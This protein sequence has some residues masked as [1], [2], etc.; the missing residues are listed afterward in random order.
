M[1]ASWRERL[2][3]IKWQLPIAIGL[4]LLIV[5]AAV[6]TNAYREVHD[7]ALASA[8]TRLQDVGQQLSTLLEQSVDARIAETRAVAG[9][10]AVAGALASRSPNAR[11]GAR[12]A[13]SE[14]RATSPQITAVELWDTAGERVA[15]VQDPVAV[16][17][18]SRE[19][20]RW[21]TAGDTIAV[22]GFR[23]D[24]EQI[25]YAVAAA[26]RSQGRIIGHV[27]Q[28][29]LLSS[30]PESA[31]LIE[32]LIGMDAAFFF[33]EPG[34]P[35]TDLVGLVERPNLPVASDGRV[36]DY[37]AADGVERLG[38]GTPVAATPWLVWVE[39]PSAVILERPHSF[40]A[41]TVPIGLAIV[42][43]GATGGWAVS[44]RFT[45][46][47]ERVTASAMALAD[48]RDAD[49]LPTDRRD[50]LGRLA[51]AFNV[52]AKRVR[53]AHRD[54]ETRVEERTAELQASRRVLRRHAR[55]LE[56]TN[57][58]LEAFSY[59]VSHDLRAP[60]RSI[61]GFS[62]ALLED[63]ADQLDER[64]TDYLNRVSAA[65]ERMGELI[66]DLLDLSRL[67]RGEL[68]VES[69]D[70]S[71]M[72]RELASELR[73]REPERE[74]EFR[75]ADDVRVEGDPHLLRAVVENLIENAWKFTADEAET[76]IEFGVADDDGERTF[77][78]RDNGAGFDMEYVD[79]L[80]GAFQ[81]LHSR[82][83][84]P[85]SGIGLAT[86]KRIVHR[87]GGRVRAEGEVGRGATFYFTLDAATDHGGAT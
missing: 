6:G 36:R 17:A 26:V 83:D 5:V 8:G 87:H 67:T 68:S 75:I 42:L 74:A 2:R 73:R 72:V 49:P 77:F 27:V 65:A 66:D 39:F 15:A 84:Y 18:A 31:R 71:A 57:E 61:N 86:V 51:E 34:G 62:Q 13:L 64:G 44:R 50:E 59:S 63:C 48:G 52:M 46:R 81:R 11:A 35:W 7:A 79:Q 38:V 55:E 12:A 3:S 24:G 16:A 20:R 37:V 78:V 82:G 70:L 32:D 1:P 29:R 14:L 56:A 45:R 21:W 40:L 85:G 25:S 80:F 28:R 10:A 43:L 9:D 60:L 23:S 58:E 47:L 4:L 33:G 30:S 69:V 54:L 53:D 41:R 76:R 22:S 19:P